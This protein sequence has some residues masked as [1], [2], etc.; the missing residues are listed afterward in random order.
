ML[1]D[2]AQSATDFEAITRELYDHLRRIVLIAK[3]SLGTHPSLEK[4]LTSVSAMIDANP[5]K[6]VADEGVRA[7]ATTLLA[8]LVT[9]TTK[10]RLYRDANS[11]RV[12]TIHML[13]TINA[14]STNK[15]VESSPIR[16]F[17]T[18]LYGQ[19]LVALHLRSAAR[20]DCEGAH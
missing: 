14:A 2:D 4:M 15:C 10:K 19:V 1:P 6:G 17:D 20:H 8:Q 5:T 7:V 11:V 9:A 18:Y 3:A 12:L 16:V 13:C